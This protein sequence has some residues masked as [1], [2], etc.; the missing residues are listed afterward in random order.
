MTKGDAEILQAALIGYAEQRRV[1]EAKIAEIQEQLAGPTQEVAASDGAK[2]KRKMSAA[3]KRR[4]ALAQKARWAAFHARS[5][6]PAPKRTAT[7]KKLSPARKA[8][9]LPNLKKAR[10][11]RAAKRTAG[12]A[13]PF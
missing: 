12:E 4:I 10:A 7:K 3:A 11:A 1:I 6:K 2:P 8:A 9:L 5:E 13:V